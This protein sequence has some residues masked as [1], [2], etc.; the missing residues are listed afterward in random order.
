MD[1]GISN[2]AVPNNIRVLEINLREVDVAFLSHGHH[3]H[4]GAIREVLGSVSK[5]LDLV[6]HPDAFLDKRIRKL[7]DG[8]EVPIPSLRSEAVDLPNVSVIEV[9][10]PTLIADDRMATLTNIPRQTDFETGMPSTFYKEGGQLHRDHIKDD[11]GLVLHV[12]DKGLVILTGCGHSGIINTILYAREVTGVQDIFAVLGG[13]HLTGPHFEK[14]I[15]PTIQEMKRFSPEI[16][17]PC[18]C[19][20]WTAVGAFKR[21]FPESFVLNSVGTKIRI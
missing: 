5:P 7:P 6:V 3:D 17:V 21:A 16:I 14:I 15:D 9:S 10:E 1:F 11:Q 18:H 13:F 4:I 20:G 8:K 19:T 2:L 12:K